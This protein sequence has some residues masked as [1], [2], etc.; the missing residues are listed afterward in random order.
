MN[1]PDSLPSARPQVNAILEQH[2]KLAETS[3]I[4]FLVLT[5]SYAALLGL[6]VYLP[7]LHRPRFRLPLHGVFLLVFLSSCVL[8]ANTAHQGGRLVHQFGVHA[9]VSD[10][11][12][13]NS[14]DHD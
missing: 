5:V 1:W 7:L 13:A 6:A 4:T 2:E 11:S 9:L 12:S 3:R 14:T 8:L 10:P